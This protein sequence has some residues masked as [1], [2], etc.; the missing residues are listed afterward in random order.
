[1]MSSR[2]IIMSSREPLGLLHWKH[3]I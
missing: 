1:L 2:S 3:L